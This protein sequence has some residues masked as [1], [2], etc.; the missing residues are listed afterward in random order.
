MTRTRVGAPNPRKWPN[1]ATDAPTIR[2]ESKEV[3]VTRF[4]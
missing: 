1:A 3:L 2:L 4:G